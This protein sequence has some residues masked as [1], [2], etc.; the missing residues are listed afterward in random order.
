MSGN[1]HK[2]V[3]HAELKGWLDNCVVPLLVREF[4]AEHERK[5]SLEVL[6]RS[7]AKSAA[8][9]ELSGEVIQ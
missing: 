2:P 7:V 6:R 8:K 4:L 9:N 3:I 5:K 1:G